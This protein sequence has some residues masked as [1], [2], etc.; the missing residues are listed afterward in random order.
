MHS[1]AFHRVQ[2]TRAWMRR[3]PRARP[4]FLFI[5]DA[6][7]ADTFFQKRAPA[8][9]F[10]VFLTIRFFSLPLLFS[11]AFSLSFSCSSFLYLRLYTSLVFSLLNPFQFESVVASRH[12]IFR[13]SSTVLSGSLREDILIPDRT[14]SRSAACSRD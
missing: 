9:L 6:G 14:A 5:Y 10:Y 11:L 1:N 3:A 2:T 7:G 12:V 8:L 13:Y 4:V